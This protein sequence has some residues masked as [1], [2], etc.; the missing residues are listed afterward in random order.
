MPELHHVSNP[1]ELEWFTNHS[2]ITEDVVIF[3][4]LMSE[5]KK[6]RAFPENRYVFANYGIR[7]YFAMPSNDRALIDPEIPKDCLK[8][9]SQ[10]YKFNYLL[11]LTVKIGHPMMILLDL[12]VEADQM[13]DFTKALLRSSFRDQFMEVLRSY[14]SPSQFKFHLYAQLMLS[15]IPVSF[16]IDHFKSNAQLFL[17]SSM[18]AMSE[19]LKEFPIDLQ[20]VHKVNNILC[21]VVDPQEQQALD[22]IKKTFEIIYARADLSLTDLGLDVSSIEFPLKASFMINSG[23]HCKD[24]IFREIAA[25]L[26]VGEAIQVLKFALEYS[27]SFKPSG[28]KIAVKIYNLLPA[29][30]RRPI[31]ETREYLHAAVQWLKLDH[32]EIFS[33]GE[34][35]HKFTF[36]ADSEQI[37]DGLFEDMTY[38]H[39]RNS[40]TRC[41]LM[42]D[43]GTDLKFY[44]AKAFENFIS[45]DIRRILP[46]PFDFSLPISKDTLNLL[47]ESENLRF[48][49]SQHGYK[50]VIKEAIFLEFINDTSIERIPEMAYLMR[51]TFFNLDIL[52]K[53]NDPSSIAKIEKLSQKGIADIV[54]IALDLLKEPVAE[55]DYFKIRNALI[56]WMNGPQRLRLSE[57]PDPI[58]KMIFKEFPL[59]SHYLAR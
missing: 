41:V 42:S 52:S 57:L 7:R 19:Y 44:S 9:L 5:L 46:E 1:A 4:S 49:A 53:I 23:N 15:D 56:Y 58:K 11:E 16:Y 47:V 29:E 14:E 17:S 51:N 39:P 55:I 22:I 38:Y 21:E 3:G 33:G 50:L 40:P 54:K 34:F 24:V 36:R 20:G 28:L 45:Q 35:S 13:K 26:D 43:F 27:K 25:S 18:I 8:I 2:H 12:I 30:I 32:L 31:H 6:T 37:A 59:T 10:G 48:I